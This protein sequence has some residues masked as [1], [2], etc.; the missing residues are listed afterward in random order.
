[1]T[2]ETHAAERPTDEPQPAPIRDSYGRWLKGTPS[3]NPRGRE[4]GSRNKRSRVL[5][6]DW[7]AIQTPG[8]VDAAMSALMGAVA[9]GKVKEAAAMG[10]LLS[11]RRRALAAS[12]LERRLR[13]L[14]G[15][16][17]GEGLSKR[18]ST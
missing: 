10:I 5:Q 7:T 14:E 1:M 3:P 2:D 15:Q 8:D 12:D 4:R 17:G 6:T 18:V 11:E 13:A 16:G 9:A